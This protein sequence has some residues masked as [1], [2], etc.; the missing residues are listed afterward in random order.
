MADANHAPSTELLTLYQAR[1][2][3]GAGVIITGNV[4]VDARAITGPAGVVLEDEQHLDKF[5]APV[6]GGVLE[7]RTG[8]DAD[9]PSRA[10]DARWPWAGR[11]WPLRR[12]RWILARSLHAF[13]CR[14]PWMIK[15]SP[16]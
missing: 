10:A 14:G 6:A 15:I 13:A 2:Q 16:T 5:R 8:V 4:M 3:G 9:K 11:R 1:A 7:G 12:W